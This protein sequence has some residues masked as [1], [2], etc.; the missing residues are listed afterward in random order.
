MLYRNLNDFAKLQ[1]FRHLNKIAL[2]PSRD[3]SDLHFRL[4]VLLGFLPYFL[5]PHVIWLIGAICLSFVVIASI[6]LGLLAGFILTVYMQGFL[7]LHCQQILEAGWELRIVWALTR[8][9]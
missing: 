9:W 4:N 3:A 2:L 7:Y 1:S 5:R 6:L 8:H